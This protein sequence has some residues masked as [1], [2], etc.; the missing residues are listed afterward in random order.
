MIALTKN[1]VEEVD[2][3]V[4]KKDYQELTLEVGHSIKRLR[5]TLVYHIKSG[6]VRL[7]TKSEERILAYM[8]GY[9]QV[10]HDEL[11]IV[12]QTE[13]VISW[14][15]LED[16]SDH[17]VLRQE[18]MD[19]LR[20]QSCWQIRH[21]ECLHGT[22]EERVHSLLSYLGERF[23]S[24][25][26]DGFYRIPWPVTHRQIANTLST[27]RVTITR[28]MQKL[29][30]TGAILVSDANEITVKKLCPV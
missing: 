30:E 2:G 3:T 17:G 6:V 16:F 1:L 19:G 11:E 21:I 25:G 4:V 5:V 22:S 26:V 20:Q 7:Q 9:F 18:V 23:G 24:L 8:T 15:Y 14:H 10:P 28:S 12:A 27:T 13:A 29:K